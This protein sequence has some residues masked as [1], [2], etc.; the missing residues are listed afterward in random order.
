MP[1]VKFSDEFVDMIKPL[2]AAFERSIPKQIEYWARV[3]KLAEEHPDK[4]FAELR[5]LLIMG[6]ANPVKQEPTEAIQAGIN[7]GMDAVG[8]LCL[9][10]E[11]D[12]NQPEHHDP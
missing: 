4:P 5:G 9:Q 2:A 12:V 11:E 3:G 8:I 6:A 10:A 7:A 1:A